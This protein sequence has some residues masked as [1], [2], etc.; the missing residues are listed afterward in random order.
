LL[1]K[2]RFRGHFQHCLKSVDYGRLKLRF[3]NIFRCK[4]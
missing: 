3:S 2:T 4:G 1:Q